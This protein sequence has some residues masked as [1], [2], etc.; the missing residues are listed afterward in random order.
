MSPCLR[1]LTALGSV[2]AIALWPNAAWPWQA[3]PAA[4]LAGLGLA[5]RLPWG[6]FLRRVGCVWLLAGLMAVGLVGTAGWELR[7]GNLFL[8][9]TLSV[10]VLSLLTHRMPLPELVAALRRLGVPR[11]WADAIGFWGRY[12]DVLAGEWRTLQLARQSRT[13]VRNRR[14]K[15]QALAN[16]LGV[17]FIRAYERAEQ[18]HQA[19][20]A[21]GYRPDA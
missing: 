2:V 3:V 15:F 18:V 5:L 9:S 6:Q 4:G 16:G 14:L 12:Y 19:M 11:I 10:W 17:L 20:L 7:T 1:L 8:K 13:L 21:R